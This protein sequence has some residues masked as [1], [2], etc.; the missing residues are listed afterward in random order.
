MFKNGH[1]YV[2]LAFND[3]IETVALVTVHKNDFVVVAIYVLQVLGKFEQLRVFLNFLLPEERGLLEQS[4][5]LLE[6]WA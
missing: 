5:E 3:E 4:D 6:F 1:Q 2:S